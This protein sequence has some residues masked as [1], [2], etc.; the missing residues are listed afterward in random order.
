MPIVEFEF[1]SLH[2]LNQWLGNERAVCEAM[3][4]DD[5]TIRL[6]AISNA[7]KF[8]K[9]ARNLP[10]VYES[11]EGRYT[12]V[13]R[14][15]DHVS[16][17]A[18]IEKGCVSSVEMLRNKISKAYGDREVLSFASKILWVKIKSPIIIYDKQVRQ[19][20]GTDDGDYCEYCRKWLEAYS[21]HEM[22]IGNACGSLHK[23]RQYCL[24][25]TV[26]T[27]RYISVIAT[28]DWFRH[29]VFDIYL[30]H[31]GDAQPGSQPRSLR[32]LDAAR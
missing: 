1:C 21:G 4:S 30:W 17:P 27:E 7:A 2:Y 9:V 24:D 23:M 22:A 28:Q 3:E 26:A 14:L 18:V 12:S 10:L 13:L 32:S 19:A 31:G 8:F 5:R 29:R 16:V 6:E 20:L 11:G 15:L 25:P